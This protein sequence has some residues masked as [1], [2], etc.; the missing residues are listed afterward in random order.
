MTTPNTGKVLRALAL[1]NSQLQTA[2]A[3]RQRIQDVAGKMSDDWIAK[4]ENPHDPDLPHHLR[5]RRLAALLSQGGQTN[6]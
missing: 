2:M 3:T 1:I 5:E 6:E 4:T